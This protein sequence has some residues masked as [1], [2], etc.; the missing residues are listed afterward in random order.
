M[1]PFAAHR[2]YLTSWSRFLIGAGAQS[3]DENRSL[4]RRGLP[5]VFAGKG[6]YTGRG[7]K[8]L[9]QMCVQCHSTGYERDVMPQKMK[10][11]GQ[12]QELCEKSGAHTEYS[13][14]NVPSQSIPN[15]RPM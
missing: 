1:F 12:A 13:N 5:W 11:T 9:Q 15:M 14:M 4:P 8:I 7:A 10:D 6:M 2:L 3:F